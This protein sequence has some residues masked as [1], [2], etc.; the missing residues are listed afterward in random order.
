MNEQTNERTNDTIILSEA[1]Q[2][3]PGAL[4]TFMSGKRESEVESIHIALWQYFRL[5]EDGSGFFSV[6]AIKD[7]Q[8]ALFDRIWQLGRSAPRADDLADARVDASALIA[9]AQFAGHSFNAKTSALLDELATGDLNG[10]MNAIK[11]NRRRGLYEA[12]KRRKFA[13]WALA[14]ERR[15]MGATESDG[16]ARLMELSRDQR[17]SHRRKDRMPVA[18]LIVKSKET[19]ANEGPATTA[20]ALLPARATTKLRDYCPQCGIRLVGNER[21]CR[22][23]YHKRQRNIRR[24]RRIKD[25]ENRRRHKVVSIDRQRAGVIALPA[26]LFVPYALLTA[27]NPIPV[28]VERISAKSTKVQRSAESRELLKGSKRNTVRLNGYGPGIENPTATL[29][30]PTIE[31]DPTGQFVMAENGQ[32]SP[33]QMSGFEVPRETLELRQQDGTERRQMS[34]FDETPIDEPATASV[35]NTVQPAS[36]NGAIQ[37][38]IDKCEPM[39]FFG[40]ANDG[41]EDQPQIDSGIFKG[42]LPDMM[43]NRVIAYCKAN[44]SDTKDTRRTYIYYWQDGDGTRYDLTRHDKTRLVIFR[45]QGARWFDDNGGDDSDGGPSFAGPPSEEPAPENPPRVQLR[46]DTESTESDAAALW[47]QW[48]ETRYRNGDATKAPHAYGYNFVVRRAM[49]VLKNGTP[50]ARNSPSPVLDPAT[51]RP[52]PD[53][54]EYNGQMS[55]GGW[56]GD[57]LHTMIRQ[58]ADRSGQDHGPVWR[59]SRGGYAFYLKVETPHDDADPAPKRRKN[60]KTGDYE[61]HDQYPKARVVYRWEPYAIEPLGQIERVETPAA[62]Q[63]I[64][65]VENGLP[66]GVAVEQKNPKSSIW[67]YGLK[68]DQPVIASLGAQYSSKRAGHWLNPDGATVESVKRAISVSMGWALPPGAYA[69]DYKKTD[70]DCILCGEPHSGSASRCTQC[71]VYYH[72][73]QARAVVIN[74]KHERK[75]AATKRRPTPQVAPLAGMTPLGIPSGT[76]SLKDAAAA[77]KVQHAQPSGW[78]CPV[79]S[80]EWEG[81]DGGQDCPKCDRQFETQMKAALLRELSA[82]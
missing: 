16:K 71:A 69:P 14:G 70:P 12:V 5:A 64:G 53:S 6:E 4:W 59:W 75:R 49:G 82:S 57:Q 18:P 78:T 60:K 50:D 46:T 33:D 45:W 54:G 81:G 13:P 63:P 3:S 51:G 66:P 47:R 11:D 29:V 22:T 65:G 68:D 36:D 30:E 37:W 35:E 17:A 7:G 32:Y 62:A 10:A 72:E 77:L 8:S 40:D 61:Y 19:T 25:N 48:G 52:L 26:S 38:L 34:M 21:V 56:Q 23:C 42:V 44:A 39:M 43:F 41:S 76:A 79:C 80:T 9:A 15:Y 1:R 31:I 67:I 58:A 24:R 74:S 55:M 2:L 28:T 73:M 27:T 20:I